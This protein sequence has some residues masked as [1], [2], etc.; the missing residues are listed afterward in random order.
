M[1]QLE[2]K[3]AKSR[4]DELFDEVAKGQEVVITRR[5]G[6]AFKIVS[7]KASQPRPTYGSAKGLIEMA[8]DFDEPLDD[9]KAYG[10]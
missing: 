1:H 2:L 9:L 4:L 7:V 6:A 8:D 10:P 5:D 3:E